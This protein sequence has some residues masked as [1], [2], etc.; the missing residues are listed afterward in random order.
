MTSSRFSTAVILIILLLVSGVFLF[1]RLG[2][3]SLWDD[4]SY[5]ALSAK[6]ILLTGDTSAW[7]GH[8][9]VGYQAGSVLSHLKD[10]YTPPLPAYLAAPALFL[11]GETAFAARLPF[12]LS[13]F[14]CICL[15]A[16]W[17]WI[18]RASLIMC[19]LVSIGLL[20]NVSFFLYCR[21]A[22]YYA[23]SALCVVAMSFIYFHWRGRMRDVV[24]LGGVSFCLFA[25]QYMIY[26]VVCTVF[27]VDYLVWGRR[28]FRLSILQWTVL[29]GLQAVLCG[30]LTLIWSPFTADV[31][32]ERLVGNDIS[33]RITLLWWNLRDLNQCEFGALLLVGIAP[34]FIKWHTPDILLRGLL[35]LIGYVILI[36]VVSP[37]PV[38]RTTVADIR[39][40]VPLI[41]LCIF[42]QA[43]VLLR[44][45]K[46]ALVRL[47][48]AVLIFGTNIVHGGVFLSNGM[49]STPLKFVGEL[50]F[51]P[52]DPY[53]VA[54]NW[55]NTHL[56]EGDS[57]WVL[58]DYAAAPLIFHAPRAVYAWQLNWPP[59]DQFLELPLIHFKGQIAP[60]Y[61]M[62][63]GPFSG[64]VQEL[65]SHWKGVHYERIET[66]DIYWKDLYRP[67]LFWR[68]FRPIVGF[69]PAIEGIQIFKKIP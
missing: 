38:E 16:W 48:L 44:L 30:A 18:D 62:A 43:E 5:T 2:H 63:F 68:T 51:P 54:S 64:H 31:G 35:A 33:E 7:I 34:F 37:Q 23:V 55:I 32:A 10:H 27:A 17:L 25:C 22:R 46:N 66:L 53:S 65:L 6:G 12:V 1:A 58:P 19:G 49:G 21:Q 26:F 13:G 60:D 8:N 39:Y 41:P 9:L 61:I 3:Y 69:D 59:K 14:A 42:L 40:L 52:R 11:L 24:L 20:C 4:E 57:V 15:V 28:S 47:A 29:L 36:S 56:S 45:T 67:E 50:I